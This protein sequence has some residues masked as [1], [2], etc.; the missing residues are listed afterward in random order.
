MNIHTEGGG[1]MLPQLFLW[2]VFLIIIIFAF[3]HL[4]TDCIQITIND[5]LSQLYSS[6]G[7]IRNQSLLLPSRI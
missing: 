7:E 5:S 2:F 3:E 4:H 1:G 6:K